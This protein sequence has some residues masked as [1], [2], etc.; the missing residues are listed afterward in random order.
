MVSA[1][2]IRL[3]IE[4]GK[5]LTFMQ[6][7]FHQD[8]LAKYGKHPGAQCNEMPRRTCNEAGIVG[9]GSST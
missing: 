4:F 5:S 6:R 1:I 9:S 3:V 7:L 2:L 8:I